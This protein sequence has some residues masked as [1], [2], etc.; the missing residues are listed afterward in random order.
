MRLPA[1]V[2]AVLAFAGCARQAGSPATVRLAVLPFENLSGDA[3]LDWMENAGAGVLASQL[4][5]SKA[6]SPVRVAAIR[7]AYS[8]KASQVLHAWY[9]RAGAGAEIH[10]QRED[11][12]SHRLDDPRVIAVN[13]EDPAGGLEQMARLIAPDAAASPTRDAAAIREWGLA[14]TART[15]EESAAAFERAAAADP[16]F[17][18]AY[19]GWAQL[20]LSGGDREGAQRVLA[21]A[22]GRQ[23]LAPQS[24]RARVDLILAE[25]R[26][27]AGARRKALSQVVAASP[28]DLAAARTLGE[29]EQSARRFPEAIALFRRVLEADPA[30]SAAR[31]SLG[32]ALAFAG[33]LHQAAEELGRYR[34]Q[35]GQE[36]NALDSLGEVHFYHGRFADAEKFFLECHKANPA[37]LGGASLRKAALARWMTGDSAGADRLFQQHLEAR[38]K[39]RDPRREMQTAEWEFL[40]G[41]RKQA[42][43]RLRAMSEGT[44]DI[45]AVAGAQL[46]FWLLETGQKEAARL[47]AAGAIKNAQAPP[48]KG[49]ALVARIL[50]EP[51]VDPGTFFRGGQG[52][53]L[54]EGAA[55]IVAGEF[56]KALPIY[57]KLYERTPPGADGLA[58]TLYAWCLLQT[59][60]RAEAAKLVQLYPIPASGGDDSVGFSIYPRF[61]GVRAA[62]LGDEAARK[63]VAAAQGDSPSVFVEP[64]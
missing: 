12:A 7:D 48:I 60:Q 63:R 57:K 2:I 28:A 26:G 5:A 36:A 37:F 31:N 19:L 50:T 1:F 23:K 16:D 32:Y 56:A 11:L 10:F 43:A 20:L 34:K 35:P 45:A 30:D 8:L 29:L 33:D 15:R 55:A 6:V 25:L 44:G 59:G 24:D 3:S 39:A 18:Q 49:I 47:A 52:Q 9:Q 54:V 14:Q 46:T 61:L 51:E 17:A 22:A 41:K 4:T 38:G 58:R 64:K 21:S 62:A 53:D 42:M 40:Q 13:P 27:D